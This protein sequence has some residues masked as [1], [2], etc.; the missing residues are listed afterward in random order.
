[1]K[2]INLDQLVLLGP[3]SEWLWTAI[4]GIVLAITFIAIYGQL[5]L[6]RSAAAIEQASMLRKE[7]QV[8][9]LVKA[10]VAIL[11]A[12]RDGRD[13]ATTQM[14]SF[15]AVGNYWERIGYLVR[16]GHIDSKLMNETFSDVDIWWM[17]LAPT[18]RNLRRE[19]SDDTLGEH[20]EWL[21][22]LSQKL[23]AKR[24]ATAVDADALARYLSIALRSGIEA[25]QEAEE[26]R[27]IVTRP[28]ASTS[29]EPERDPGTV[30]R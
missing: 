20:F 30:A 24:G 17:W 5:R 10:K 3:G 2:L 22:A 19:M 7:W 18:T 13:L 9:E 26:A 16:A 23:D 25:L 29:L 11:T 27:G 8:Y 12:I 15:Q 14:R 4:S 6:Q 28:T 1:M 21:A